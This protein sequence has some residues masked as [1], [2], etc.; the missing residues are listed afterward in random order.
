MAGHKT[1]IT[2]EGA[3][4]WFPTAQLRAHTDAYLQSRGRIKPEHREARLMK[5]IKD[6]AQKD[7]AIVAC[8]H[9]LSPHTAKS[10]LRGELYM[11]P[12]AQT[13]SDTYLRAL[14]AV[15]SVNPTAVSPYEAEWAQDLLSLAP[16][17][18]RSSSK[19]LE[20]YCKRLV[21]RSPSDLLFHNLVDGE[22]RKAC[23]RYGKQLSNLK[24][25]CRWEDAF[26]AAR[27]LA[28]LPGKFQY[29][30]SVLDA[31]FFEWRTWAIWNPNSLRI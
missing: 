24:L 28:E 9:I 31:T 8:A 15:G 30:E 23:T 27:W 13:G 17:D 11:A 21:T 18:I 4:E 22:L 3:N 19:R 5:L 10:L 14:A 20:V 6:H 12:G 26:T 7:A 1:S 29:M 16:Q 2:G 25:E